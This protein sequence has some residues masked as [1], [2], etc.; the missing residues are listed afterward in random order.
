[1]TVCAKI[2]SGITLATLQVPTKYQNITSIHAEDRHE[3]A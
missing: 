1:M 3:D 2:I